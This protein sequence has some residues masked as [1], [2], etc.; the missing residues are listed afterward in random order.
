VDVRGRRAVGV[1][2]DERMEAEYGGKAGGKAIGEGEGWGGGKRVRGV[3]G[4][5][6]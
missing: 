2:R 6:R 4:V 1:E 3:E 5:L